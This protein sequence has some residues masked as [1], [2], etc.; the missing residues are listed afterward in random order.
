MA[1]NKIQIHISFDYELFFGKAAGSAEKCILEPTQKLIDLAKAHKV[2][3]IFFVD[4]GY[5]MQLKNHSHIKQCNED[6]IRVSSQIKQLSLL[7]HEIALHIHPHWEDSCYENNQW[8][9]NTKR[10]KLADFKN[11]EIDR[12]VSTY[13]QAIKDIIGKP[14]KSYRAGGWCIQPFE[15]IKKALQ[16][17]H[18]FTDSTVYNN[19]FHSSHAHAYDFTKA[20][21]LAEWKF[22]KDPCVVN[23]LGCFT[24]IPIT[25]DLIPP[26]FYWKLYL[27]M[28]S[29]P[30]KYKPIGDG[31]WLVDRKRIYKH[32]YT[33]TPHFACCDGYFASRLLAILAKTEKQ[34]KK[35]MMVLSHPKSM[36]PY[37]FNELDKFIN[38]AKTKGHMVNTIISS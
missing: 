32:F 35:R 31:N 9:I 33:K 34:N 3:F 20:P 4:A 13:H 17:N 30:L 2:P 26:L 14:C 21:D 19:G 15:L 10:Y 27:K 6:F 25:P 1:N 16:A 18:I 38:H 12:I 7:G 28:R 8:I 24:E 29:E 23:P 37:S 5:L 22:E 11:E 36:A